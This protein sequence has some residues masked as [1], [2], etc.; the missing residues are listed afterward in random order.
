[1]QSDKER[2]RC[3]ICDSRLLAELPRSLFS[4]VPSPLIH[5]QPLEPPPPSELATHAHSGPRSQECRFGSA[6]MW[7]QCQQTMDKLYVSPKG[8]A[9][10]VKWPLSCQARTN[11]GREAMPPRRPACDATVESIDWPGSLKV[12]QASIVRKSFLW[13]E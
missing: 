3:M 4:F 8:E 11:H 2:P 6:A 7:I 12:I 10:V 5:Q 1:M 9:V 13:P